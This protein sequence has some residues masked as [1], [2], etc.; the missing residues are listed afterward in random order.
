MLLQLIILAENNS[1]LVRQTDILMY[2][3][4]IAGFALFLLYTVVKV[5][6]QG[7]YHRLFYVLFKQEYSATSFNESNSSFINAGYYILFGSALSIAS[8]IFVALGYRSDFS[9]YFESQNVITTGLIIL[10][11]VL[12]YF[13]VKWLIYS[14]WG[15]LFEFSELSQNYINHFF[16]NQR[17]L[18][19]IIFPIFF[20]CPFVPE[21]VRNI[22]IYIAIGVVVVSTLYAF[23][24]FWRYTMKIK[25]FNH[26]AIL[27]FCAFE[28]LPILVVWRLV[29]G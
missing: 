25:F 17:A 29:I 10:G 28:I 11:S 24:T 15:W 7:Y 13:L 21:S 4:A 12:V 9:H 6:H 19:I 5:V 3:V 27:Y 16:Y 14:F 18:G 1:I 22:L 8:M 23:Y 2:V 20:V 26:Y